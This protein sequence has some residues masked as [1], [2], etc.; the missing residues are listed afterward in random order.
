MLWNRLSSKFRRQSAQIERAHADGLAVNEDSPEAFE[1]ILWRKYFDHKHTASGISL[2]STAD[3]NFVTYFREHM[4]KIVLARQPGHLKE[5]RYVS[6]NNN[7]VGR[8]PALQ[9]MVSDALIVVPVRD[10]LEHAIS[11]WSQHQNFSRRQ[12]S[13]PF[14][15]KY[16]EDIGHYE[17]G[18]LH[19]PIKFPSVGVL[20]EDRSPDS[21]D[22]WL[23]YWIAAFEHLSA[24]EGIVFLSYESLCRS[25]VESVTQLSRQLCIRAT[26]SE[27]EDAASMLRGAT[28][29]RKHVHSTDKEL[30]ERAMFVYRELLCCCLPV[31][32]YH[33][34]ANRT[35]DA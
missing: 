35:A 6:K 11:L 26:G 4:Q 30:S 21:I 3:S 8:I 1:E 33:T 18:T 5:G 28:P 32:A 14:V 10:P 29:S 27:I 16:M 23:A 15:R 13:D 24:C 2:W 7:N 9:D 19:R 17:F 12:A 25:P 34:N 20:T 22:Y 31:G